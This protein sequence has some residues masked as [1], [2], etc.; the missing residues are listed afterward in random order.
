MA[1]HPDAAPKTDEEYET[2]EQRELRQIFQ[3]QSAVSINSILI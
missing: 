2:G 1:Q 3:G